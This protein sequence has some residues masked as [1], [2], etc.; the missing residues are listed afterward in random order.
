MQKCLSQFMIDDID[1]LKVGL[2]SYR[3]HDEEGISYLTNIDIDFTT[4][5]QHL[6]KSFMSINCWGGRDEPEAV[7]DGLKVAINDVSWREESIKFIYHILDAPCH[8]EKY[9][10]YEDDK[11]KECPCEINIEELFLEMRKKNIKYTIIKLNDSI[12][13]MTKEFQKYINLEIIAPKITIDKS[14]IQSQKILI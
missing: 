12:D 1:I 3:D 5:T 13:K 6:I 14:K 4:N 7:F 9:N 11:Y 8:G 2:V 10:N